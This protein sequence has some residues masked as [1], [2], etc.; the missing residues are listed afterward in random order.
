[1]LIVGSC[2]A[3]KNSLMP[4]LRNALNAGRWDMPIF[5]THALSITFP[6]WSGA[7]PIDDLLDAA[8]GDAAPDDP[9]T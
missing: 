1:M 5:R 6:G 4:A 9:R 7:Q 3:G 2:G 8:P